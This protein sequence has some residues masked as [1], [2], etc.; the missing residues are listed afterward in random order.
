M[1]L[2]GEIMST[3]TLKGQN[4]EVKGNLPGLGSKAPDFNLVNESLENVSLANFQGKRKVLNIFPSVDTPTCA[5]SVRKF[6]AEAS[7]L[8][9]TIVIN[10]SQDLP[11]AQKRFCAAEGLKNVINLS[12]FRDPSFLSQYGVYLASGPLTGL[13]ARAVLVLDENNNVAHVELVKEIADEPNYN[14]ALK[15]LK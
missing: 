11:F 7:N 1:D 2:I 6:N 5:T 13:C 4:T 9:N 14:D 15:V 10:I 12:S 8:N 3:V